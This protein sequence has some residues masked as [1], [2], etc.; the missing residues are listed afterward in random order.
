MLI[1]SLSLIL[2]QDIVYQTGLQTA[3]R[4]LL[5]QKG[6]SADD[7][8]NNPMFSSRWS[9]VT[10]LR[11]EELINQ[12]LLQ[13]VVVP[14]ADDLDLGPQHPTDTSMRGSKGIE[15]CAPDTQEYWD[16][17]AATL[18]KQYV[19][20]CTEPASANGVNN[21]IGKSA[22]NA[23]FVGE[24]NKST[25][26]IIMEVDN[27]QESAVRP[28]DRKPPPS[29]TTISK[30]LQG[31]LVARGGVANEDGMRIAP[32]DNDVIFLCDGNRESCKNAMCGP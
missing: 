17:F 9:E 10:R 32:C 27:L 18:V 11:G 26:A 5:V 1:V 21:E 13:Q 28:L 6:T 2:L 15:R 3:I 12:R 23:G 7:I 25:V 8:M 31:V 20:L 16:S 4:S 24:T 19:K 30:L 22:L 14:D 29:Q